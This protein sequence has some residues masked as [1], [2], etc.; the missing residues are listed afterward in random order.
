MNCSDDQ[1]NSYLRHIILFHS[2]ADVP[3]GNMTSEE[4][5]HPKGE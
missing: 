3:M 4:A 1:P 2:Y 5:F